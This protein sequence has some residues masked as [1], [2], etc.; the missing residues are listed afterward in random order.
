MANYNLDAKIIL[1][2]KLT[3]PLIGSKIGKTIYLETRQIQRDKK[4]LLLCIPDSCLNNFQIEYCI[5]QNQP[6]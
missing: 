6:L 4:T 2:P 3:I 5:S 1:K